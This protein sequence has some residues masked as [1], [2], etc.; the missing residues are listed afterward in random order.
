MS[1]PRQWWRRRPAAQT[2]T[3]LGEELAVRGIAPRRVTVY[4]PPGYDA[5]RARP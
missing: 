1:G 3:V 4:L 5:A 2:V